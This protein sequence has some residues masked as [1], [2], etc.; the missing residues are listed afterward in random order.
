MREFHL[1]RIKGVWG[2]WCIQTLYV[3]SKDD[4]FPFLCILGHDPL[5]MWLPHICTYAY[6]LVPPCHCTSYKQSL[7]NISH[8]N[9]YYLLGI[10]YNY[11]SN[12]IT[13]QA[14][15]PIRLVSFI[16]NCCLTCIESL[17]I[18]IHISLSLSKELSDCNNPIWIEALWYE[19]FCSLKSPI[20]KVAVSYKPR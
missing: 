4:L 18:C 11:R 8:M 17:S 20:S 6:C 12:D 13:W 16:S 15:L 3:H 1:S 5:S 7:H 19:D 9:V 10:I 2:L 14:N